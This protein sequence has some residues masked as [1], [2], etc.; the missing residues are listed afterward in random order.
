MAPLK[1]CAFAIAFLLPG[2]AA[3]DG[4]A[5]LRA[6]VL[7]LHGQTPLK[8]IVTAKVLKRQGEGRE[9]QEDEGLG[10][11]LVDA[12]PQ[13]LRI[14]YDAETLVR[15]RAE[16]T[17]REGSATAKMPVVFALNA[18]TYR[19]V[20]ELVEAA[21]A[22]TRTLTRSTFRS[23]RSDQWNDKPARLL[24][25]DVGLGK[26][27]DRELK[28]IKKHEGSLDI[29]IGADGTPL[30]SRMRH[31]VSGRALVVLTFETRGDEDIIYAVAGDRLVA[32]RKEVFGAGSGAGEKGEDRTQFTLQFMP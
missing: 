13:G 6:A 11:V 24:S 26:L 30:A 28:Y 5:D 19:Q 21:D 31:T 32:T 9:L 23:E 8:A 16:D 10:T 14:Q 27:S 29:W 7:R 15:V 4:Q 2:F 18:L 1:A 22:L 20:H 25:F 12:G 3:A 17:A